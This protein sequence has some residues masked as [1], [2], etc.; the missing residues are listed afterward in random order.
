MAVYEVS[1]FG[2]HKAVSLLPLLRLT[3]SLIHMRDRRRFGKKL[4][5]RLYV[6]FILN[7]FLALYLRNQIRE[8]VH[9]I[10]KCGCRCFMVELN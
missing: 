3:H 1:P 2:M 10:K 8:L 5:A 4:I 7:L 6:F 9:T